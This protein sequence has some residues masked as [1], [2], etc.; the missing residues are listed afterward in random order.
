MSSSVIPHVMGTAMLIS[1]FFVISAYYAYSYSSI[2]N[3]V[4]ASQLEEVANY[5]SSNIID[6]VSL[7]TLS[8]EDQFLVKDL[9]V[10]KYIANN[11]YEITI[12]RYMEPVTQEGVL[13]VRVYLVFQPS[14]YGVSYLPWSSEGNIAIF[15]G[16]DPGVP[17][18][19]SPHTSVPSGYEEITIWSLK[20]GTNVTI[21]L[22]IRS[23]ES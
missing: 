16:T 11:I 1:L 9:T 3:G 6:M 8:S 19:L 18:Y 22:G 10:P 23:E 15:N 2:Q 4:I 7:T 20:R 21:G 14:V 13:R 5:V 17:S 12:E